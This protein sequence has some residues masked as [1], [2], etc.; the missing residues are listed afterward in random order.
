MTEPSSTRVLTVDPEAPE[1][2]ALDEA[3]RVLAGGGLV[4]F[5]TETV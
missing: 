2:S 5:A 1:P 4:A 3:A